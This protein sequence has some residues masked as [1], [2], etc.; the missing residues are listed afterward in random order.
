M[1]DIYDFD[2]VSFT[3]GDS[4]VELYGPEMRTP[5]NG[6][7]VYFREGSWLEK[8]ENGEYYADW[9][10]TWFYKDKEHP[11]NY[12]YFEQDSWPTALYNMQGILIEIENEERVVA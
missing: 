7:T 1:S 6:E 3:I 11:E 8:D 9:N 4:M 2:P 10:L 5:V 12:L